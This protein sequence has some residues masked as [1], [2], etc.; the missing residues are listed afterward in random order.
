MIRAGVIA[1]WLLVWPA[2]VQG[3]TLFGYWD[4][5]YAHAGN[6]QHIR[7]TAPYSNVTHAV[8]WYV[9]ADWQEAA[10]ANLGVVLMWP[11]DLWLTI[12]TTR[13][14]LWNTPVW[15][16]NALQFAQAVLAHRDQVVAVN[17]ID[18]PD[19]NYAGAGVYAWTVDNCRRQA[20]KIEANIS[21]V[22]TVFPWA[23]TMVI[24]SAMWANW[25]V[26]DDGSPRDPS[27]YGVTL[28]SADWVG[29]DCYTPFEQCFGRYKSLP[30]LI[31]GMQARMTASQRVALVPRA[32]SGD[33]LGFNPSDA[34]VASIAGQY[35]T[36]ARSNTRVCCVFPFIW[37]DLS[38]TLRG[39]QSSPTIRSALEQIGFSLT[40]KTTLA[41][42][43][44]PGPVTGL[45]FVR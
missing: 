27:R 16:G 40:G 24:Y 15:G 8:R 12:D 29:L 32:F 21:A 31:A 43:P 2:L 44:P 34:Q 41:P 6:E 13:P 19:C 5:A 30:T 45:R 33:Y 28:A 36:Y 1:A 23:K 42:P 10:S 26:N 11:Y 9:E 4:H 20:A 38:P 3:Q 17:V 14:I 39:A 18:E 7:D 37:W 22:R 35:A 25:F